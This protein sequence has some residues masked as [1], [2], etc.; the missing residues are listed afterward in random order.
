MYP[1]YNTGYMDLKKQISN[2]LKTARVM[3]LATSVNN[4][5]W[6]CNVHYYSDDDLNFFWVSMTSRRHS[7]EIEKNPNVA[8]TVKIHE[9]TM[10]EKYVIGISAEG[11]AEVLNNEEVNKIGN[12]YISKLDKNPKLL[13][14]I[15]ADKGDF[16]FYKL[17]PSKI[18]LFDIK[19]FPHDPRQ[20]YNV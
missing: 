8:V 17:T 19:T 6:A 13:E 18:V 2:Y 12:Q 16:K 11:K 15:L 14:D 20:E 5:P 9:D 4:H 3:Q 1:G 10:E 7:E